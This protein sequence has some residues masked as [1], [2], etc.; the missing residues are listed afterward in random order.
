MDEI[1]KLLFLITEHHMFCNNG[2]NTKI[3]KYITK[4]YECFQNI[5]MYEHFTLKKTHVKKTG[6]IH[7][8][9]KKM[10][11]FMYHLLDITRKIYKDETY[12]TKSVILPAVTIID[13][14]MLAGE[15]IMIKS[16][17]RNLKV[18]LDDFGF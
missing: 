9:K 3:L 11:S 6:K 12:N 2:N 10:T 5:L 8:A 7:H 14:E 1:F 18:F 13:E 16:T 4:L 17:M 15:C